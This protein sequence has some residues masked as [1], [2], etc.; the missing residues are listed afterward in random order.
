MR[1]C[2]AAPADPGP[3]ERGCCK[4]PEAPRPDS[5]SKAAASTSVAVA[6]ETFLAGP[7]GIVASPVPPT[8]VARLA[9][10]DHRSPSPDDSPPD[11]LAELRILLI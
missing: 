10:R 2:C 4:S 7:A 9:R 5:T 11:R 6:I 3:A 8:V 1:P